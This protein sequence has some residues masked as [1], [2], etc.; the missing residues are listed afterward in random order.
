[1]A[2][3]KTARDKVEARLSYSATT[4]TSTTVSSSSSTIVGE[5]VAPDIFLRLRNSETGDSFRGTSVQGHVA[6]RDGGGGWR[7]WELL[8]GLGVVMC[9]RGPELGATMEA[10]AGGPRAPARVGSSNVRPSSRTGSDD[11]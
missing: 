6:E 8:L 4:V 2:Q 1:M 10:G 7:G 3:W 11:A 9:G 5:H